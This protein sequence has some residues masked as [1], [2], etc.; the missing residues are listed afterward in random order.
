MS[1]V[2]SSLVEKD[3]LSGLS[4]L[5]PSLNS[6]NMSVERRAL[7]GL[8]EAQSIDLT[9]VLRSALGDWYDFRDAL[10]HLRK[11]QAFLAELPATAEFIESLPSEWRQRIAKCAV[12][13]IQIIKS[14]LEFQP[15][16]KQGEPAPD[17]QR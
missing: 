4:S 13:F 3:L 17:Q 7:L 8:S 2:E 11:M 14:I 9:P 12:S 16:T 1:E 10:P 5:I 15:V 6:V